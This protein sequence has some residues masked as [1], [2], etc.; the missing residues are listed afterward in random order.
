[1][2]YLWLVIFILI[3]FTGIYVILK[4]SSKKKINSIKKIDFLNKLK[5]IKTNASLKEPIIDYDKLY[6]KIL[7][8]LWYTGSFGEILKLKPVEVI[9]LNKI[10]ELH[11]LRNKL[12]H[13]FDNISEIILRKKTLEYEKEINTLL[14]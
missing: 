8:E 10:W 6:H 11:K 1:M 5:K 14:R 4:Y 7:L 13:D 12:V 9:N 2:M 3:I